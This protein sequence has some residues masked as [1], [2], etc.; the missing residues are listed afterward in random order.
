MPEPAPKT[1]LSYTTILRW[2]FGRP[3]LD[4]DERRILAAEARRST[5]RLVV[6]ARALYVLFFF[7]S[8]PI[9][10]CLACAPLALMIRFWPFSESW[11]ASDALPV[12]VA[13]I[14]VLSSVAA[15]SFVAVIP[16]VSA[17]ASLLWSGFAL[18]KGWLNA[19]NAQALIRSASPYFD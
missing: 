19:A 2:H 12:Q 14:G 3:R 8:L 10:V 5:P 13:M 15:I 11:L 9:G 6:R 7:G 17:L 1:G 16:A 4:P 18:R